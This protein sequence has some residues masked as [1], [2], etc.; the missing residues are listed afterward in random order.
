MW[1]VFTCDRRSSIKYNMSNLPA[2]LDKKVKKLANPRALT[3]RWARTQRFYINP[4]FRHIFDIESSPE[5]FEKSVEEKLEL[6]NS[7][8]ESDGEPEYKVSEYEYRRFLIWMQRHPNVMR[9]RTIM[10]LNRF[11]DEKLIEHVL[12]MERKALESEDPNKLINLH[13][14][15]TGYHKATM[16]V[17]GLNIN[18]RKPKQRKQESKPLVDENGMLVGCEKIR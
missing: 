7:R 3:L 5:Q 6:V 1:Q 14:F 9:A 17:L 4:K 10:L 12:I 2:N 8:E 16:E 15:I 18:K 13:K 11:Q